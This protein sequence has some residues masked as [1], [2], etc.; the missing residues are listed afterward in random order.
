MIGELSICS[1]TPQDLCGLPIIPNNQPTYTRSNHSVPIHHRWSVTA[2]I[3]YLTYIFIITRR[4]K[5]TWYLV[6][7]VVYECV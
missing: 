1:L 6:T 2:L 7:S 3:T 4:L 5:E